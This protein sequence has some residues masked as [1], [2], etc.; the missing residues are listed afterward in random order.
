MF[1]HMLGHEHRRTRSQTASAQTPTC[2]PS[3]IPDLA[4]AYVE[5][6][7]AVMAHISAQW[8]A[9][10]VTAFYIGTAYNTE[11]ILWDWNYCGLSTIIPILGL[12]QETLTCLCTVLKGWYVAE[13]TTGLVRLSYLL[14][15]GTNSHGTTASGL[16]PRRTPYATTSPSYWTGIINWNPRF[17]GLGYNGMQPDAPKHNVNPG[18]QPTQTWAVT[19]LIC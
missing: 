4:A 15:G 18:I 2:P 8:W 1:L 9:Q 14:F 13:T 10:Y 17:V 16:K 7:Q 19:P 12:D 3:T 6:V 11:T 5:F